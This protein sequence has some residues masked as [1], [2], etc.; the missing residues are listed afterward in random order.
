MERRAKLRRLENVRRR[1][2]HLTASAFEAIAQEFGDDASRHDLRAA[3]DEIMTDE[4]GN[5]GSILKRLFVTSA[6]GGLMT[7][8][9]AC[10]MASLQAAVQIDGSFRSHFLSCIEAQPPSYEHPWSIVP[11]SELSCTGVKF[12]LRLELS[13]NSETK[14]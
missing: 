12:R 10:P 7:L 5:H 2:P 11:R 4:Q 6:L 13:F 14:S 3:R 1:C 9:C 8:L